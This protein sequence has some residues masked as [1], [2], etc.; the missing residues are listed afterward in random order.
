MRLDLDITTPLLQIW[1]ATTAEMTVVV[2]EMSRVVRDQDTVRLPLPRTPRSI[3]L[4]R[5]QSANDPV[6]HTA[7]VATTDDAPDHRL[8]VDE[9][10]LHSASTAPATDLDHIT[11]IRAAAEAR[12]H[13][14]QAVQV[15]ATRLAT[16]TRTASI[17][18]QADRHQPNQRRSR[19]TFKWVM[20]MK[21]RI[22]KPRWR[23]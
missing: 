8:E 20:A 4:T 13:Q 19:A 14:S 1:I 15:A 21:T 18:A 16:I 9:T 23:A 5:S 3:L 12:A 22:P 17:P 2:A 10:L 7:S 11:T 6:H